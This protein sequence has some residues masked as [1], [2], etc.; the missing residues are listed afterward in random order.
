MPF[1]VEDVI[2]AERVQTGPE[3]E[4][5]VVISDREP[6]GGTIDIETG[7]ES[8]IDGGRILSALNGSDPAM[9][10]VLDILSP[11]FNMEG[12]TLSSR[13]RLI[14]RSADGTL[15]GSVEIRA[16]SNE[17]FDA[18]RITFEAGEID[19]GGYNFIR[20]N[21]IDYQMPTNW[22]GVITNSPITDNNTPIEIQQDFSGNTHIR[23]R[24]DLNGAAS[25]STIFTLPTRFRPTAQQRT[26]V[27][28]NGATFG[29]MV[30][31]TSGVVQFFTKSGAPTLLF[32]DF[33]FSTR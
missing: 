21:G 12:N 8:E 3:G 32:L 25:G 4:S 23:G 22:Q 1:P 6:W 28:G 19:L 2:E 13:I 9:R 33:T 20:I 14:G 15:P 31:N 5:R 7:H 26:L 29:I 30:V 27:D 24:A 11:L 10:G 18:G 16:V 17:S